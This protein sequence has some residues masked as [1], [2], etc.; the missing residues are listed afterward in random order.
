MD[1][2]QTALA[3]HLNI[4]A[5][6][7]VQATELPSLALS[8][9]LDAAAL[10]ELYRK[11]TLSA[12]EHLGQARDLIAAGGRDTAAYD[13][14]VARGGAHA[15]LHQA[16]CALCAVVPEIAVVGGARANVNVRPYA[17]IPRAV[18]LG[19]AALVIAGYFVLTAARAGVLW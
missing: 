10:D 18:A 6:L 16:L 7:I 5:D 4:A 9:S 1:A 8:G 14:L 19:F 13:E 11:A 3:Q 17:W 12:W 2:N 15:G